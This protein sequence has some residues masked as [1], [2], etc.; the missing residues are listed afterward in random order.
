MAYEVSRRNF[1]KGAA[2][3]A[4]AAAVSGL[5]TGCSGDTKPVAQIQLGDYTV[6]VTDAKTAQESSVAGAQKVNGYITPVV[7]IEYSG[8]GSMTLLYTDIFS[9]ELGGSKM[10]LTNPASVYN[11]TV[12]NFKS[13]EPKFKTTDKDLY[14]GFNSNTQAMKLKVTLDK[15]TAIFTIKGNGDITVAKA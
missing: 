3:A 13:C 1:M 14:A 6:R 15:E 11:S 10:T 5:M 12:G 7:G 9:A 8:K 4:A 2:M